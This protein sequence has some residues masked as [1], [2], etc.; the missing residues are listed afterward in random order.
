MAVTATPVF[1]QTP[2]HA[3]SAYTTASTTATVLSAGVNGCKITS[4]TAVSNS[5]SAHTFMVGISSGSTALPL[6]S[7]SI[8]AAS[9]TDGATPAV[10]MLSSS[11][12]PGLPVDNDGQRYLFLSSTAYALTVTASA[13]INTGKQVTFSSFYADF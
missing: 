5:T 13:T 10:D 8:P 6:V 7:V 1:V 2:K 11:I 9:G 12:L 3:T 4:L